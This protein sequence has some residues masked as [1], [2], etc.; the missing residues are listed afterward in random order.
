M[1]SSTKFATPALSML[2]PK[3][4]KSAADALA[5]RPEPNRADML[6]CPACS[7]AC[8]SAI[9]RRHMGILKGTPCPHCGAPLRLKGGR[10]LFTGYGL[11]LVAAGFVA[12]LAGPANRHLVRILAS[13]FI[14]VMVV[15]F[16]ATLRRLPLVA[17]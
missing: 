5:L 10:T 1:I 16:S 15:V 11:I 17:E 13:P 12:Y 6:T 8:I 7:T 4:A 14:I 3:Q 9:T 2:T